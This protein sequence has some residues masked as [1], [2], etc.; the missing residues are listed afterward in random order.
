MRCDSLLYVMSLTLYMQA[1]DSFEP[2]GNGKEESLPPPPPVVPSNVVPLK[3]EEVVSHAEPVKKKVSRLPIAR[4]GLGSRGNKI[5][6]LAN[7]FKVNVTKSDGHF[8]HYSVC[9]S[10]AFGLLFYEFA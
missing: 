6:L 4:R 8:F 10:F 1:M 2:D 5:Q 3:A 9:S 7:H